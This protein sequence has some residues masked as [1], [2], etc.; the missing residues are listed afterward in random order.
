MRPYYWNTR[1]GTPRA[2]ARAPGLAAA[3]GLRAEGAAVLDFGCGGLGAARLL[4]ACGAQVTGVD[5][6]PL[7]PALYSWPGDQGE[8]PRGERR[9]PG[10][11]T[12]VTGRCPFARELLEQAGL[13]V[14]AFDQ[15]DDAAARALG[16]A[17]GW[18]QGEDAM[19]LQNDLFA[20]FTVARRPAEAP[21]GPRS[22]GLRR[23]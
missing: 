21:K 8:V 22:A 13:E 15:Q 5:V 7:L 9:A 23:L 1:Y 14:P 20:W 6:D 2:H 10:R 11:L 19:D 16:A 12:L 17:L 3:H 4:A 18:D